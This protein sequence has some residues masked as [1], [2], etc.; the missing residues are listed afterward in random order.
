MENN[1]F[2]NEIIN[3]SKKINAPIFADPLSQI[4][5]GFSNKL[6]IS[7]YDIFLRNTDINPGQIIR[8]GRKPT[9]K[10]LCQLLKKHKHDTVKQQV[11]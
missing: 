7:H 6:I 11:I 4:R 2:Q 9:S 8:F 10:K 3:L 5:Y 1:L